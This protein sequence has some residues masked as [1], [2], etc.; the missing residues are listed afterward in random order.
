MSRSRSSMY[1]R[2]VLKLVLVFQERLDADGIFVGRVEHQDLV[3][4]PHRLLISALLGELPG[5]DL[6]TGDGLVALPGGQALLLGDATLLLKVVCSLRIAAGGLDRL[7]ELKLSRPNRVIELPHAGAVKSW[8]L[9]SAATC[10]R[11]MASCA[12]A[13]LSLA[14]SSRAS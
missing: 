11:V 8:R 7:R 5:G 1:P 3:N 14:M 12:C 4:D 6:Q 10:A 13:N 2:W 9:E